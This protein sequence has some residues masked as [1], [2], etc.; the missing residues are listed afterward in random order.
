MGVL[1]S[2]N[3][4]EDRSSFAIGLLAGVVVGVGAT[5]AYTCWKKL[6]DAASQGA[7]QKAS[8][9]L[10]SDQVR[11]GE[12]ERVLMDEQCKRNI[13]FLGEDNFRRIANSKIVIVGIGGTGSHAAHLLARSGAGF[14]RLIDLDQVSLSSLNRHAVAT[15]AD[16]GKSKVGVMRD[17]LMQ[18]V[19][20]M[21][22]EC[23]QDIFTME[24]GERL[25]FSPNPN[26]TEDS[27]RDFQPDFV[28]DCIDNVE[29]KAY[30]LALCH[31]ENIPVITSCGAGCRL[32]P[33]RLTVCD[34]SEA[35][36]D[37]L[38]RATK[39]VLARTYKIRSGVP[40]LFSTEK[41][42][43]KLLPF[44]E[45]DEDPSEYQT[46][47]E[48]HMRVRIVPVLGPMP[49][50]WGNALA[51]FVINA[52]CQQTYE[53]Q[54]IE[55]RGRKYWDSLLKNVRR[56][57]LAHFAN[58][59]AHAK[60][61]L[62]KEEAMFILEEQWNFQ[63]AHSGRVSP[64]RGTVILARWNPNQPLTIDNAIPLTQDEAKAH[65][66]GE[67]VWTEEQ[68]AQVQRAIRENQRL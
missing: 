9:P 1:Y 19:P 44:M 48:I 38:L 60:G 16:V 57:E 66:K 3:S 31:R 2:F 4:M 18:T 8:E 62:N 20:A 46:L 64:A 15:R 58:N 51:M 53:P 67:L 43:V 52:I 29:T 10:A 17:H 49:A 37:P 42:P 30:L 22:C 28:V 40:C 36:G 12:E 35:M 68:K 5:A 50:I 14:L 45:E 24:N 63:S 13:Q 32:D 54:P 6:P 41:P 47:P 27:R 61:T 33:T 26:N 7:Q 11:V 65:Y 59:N 21:I 34:I 39:N 56:L 23:V 55:V 25:L